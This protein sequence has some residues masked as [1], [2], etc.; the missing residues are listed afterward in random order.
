M[1]SVIHLS[2]E[3][4]LKRYTVG[5]QP[6]GNMNRAQ[7]D[8][9]IKGSRRNCRFLELVRDSWPA[10]ADNQ[11]VGFWLTDEDGDKLYEMAQEEPANA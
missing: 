10:H 9:A 8:A 2:R 11:T 5:N 6:V 4:W 1:Q 7:L 3:S